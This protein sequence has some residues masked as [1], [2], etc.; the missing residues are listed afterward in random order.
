MLSN[1]EV[2]RPPA[3]ASS[4]TRAHNFFQRSRRA[5]RGLS[6]TAPT[7]VRRAPRAEPDSKCVEQRTQRESCKKS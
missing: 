5:N 6:R 7:I 3:G 4:A 2:E 1:G